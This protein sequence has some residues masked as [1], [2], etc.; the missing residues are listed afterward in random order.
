MEVKINFQNVHFTRP[1]IH[2]NNG[3]TQLMW[4]S[5]ARL[6]NFTYASPLYVD[7][8]V[9]ISTRNEKN[10]IEQHPEQV[11]KMINIGKIPLM[12]KSDYCMLNIRSHHT[13]RHYKECAHDPWG[14]FYYQR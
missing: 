5:E 6:R 3:S 10:E 8:I 4:P 11:L 7:I 2:E 12:L 1:V 14:L 9:N 13:Q